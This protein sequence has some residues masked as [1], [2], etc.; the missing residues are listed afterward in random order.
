MF[1][2][3]FIFCHTRQL[4]KNNKIKT[5]SLI[6]CAS[7]WIAN[8]C[9]SE[10]VFEVSTIC[11]NTCCEMAMPL[12]YCYD[13]DRVVHFSPFSSTFCLST[14]TT[15]THVTIMSSQSKSGSGVVVK[16]NYGVGNCQHNPCAKNSKY[17]SNHIKVMTRKLL[18]SFLW[19]RCIVKPAHGFLWK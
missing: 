17:Q 1:V 15:T 13:C 16:F 18:A 19:T 2:Q 11:I 9:Q 7:L 6:E 12:A 3:N 4:K 10:A 14:T 8:W 5:W